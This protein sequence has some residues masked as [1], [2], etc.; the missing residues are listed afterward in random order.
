MNKIFLLAGALALMPLT[1]SAQDDTPPQTT[2]SAFCMDVRTN[3][4]YDAALIPNVGVEFALGRHWSVATNWAW[5]WWS[6][7]SMNRYWRVF[8]GELNLRWWFGGKK[9]LTGHH[10]GVYGEAFTYDVMLSSRKGYLGGIPGGGM[11][12]HPSWNVGAE[13][14][15]SQP[16]GHRL[17]L[18]FTLGVGYFRSTYYEYKPIDTHYVWQDTKKKRWIGPTKAEV[19]LVWLLGRGN[20]NNRKGGER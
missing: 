6:R 9:P 2:D 19:S 20:V 13:Y 8:G 12:R 18:D 5:A 15:F 7:R 14:G 17:N 10:L 11:L 3:L 1:A 16:I 4:L